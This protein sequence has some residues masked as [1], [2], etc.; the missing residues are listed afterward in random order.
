MSDEQ[1][2]QSGEEAGPLCG[3]RLA[4]A[5]EELQISLVEIAK[6]LHLDEQKVQALEA[7]DFAPLGAPVFA[8]GH[9][10]KYA[11]L[12][13]VD[14]D[15]ILMGYH[16][17]TRSEGLPPVVSDRKAPK[18]AASPTPWVASAVVILII[19]AVAA[20]FFLLRP[21]PGDEE[22]LPPAQAEPEIV[23]ESSAANDTA[24]TGLDDAADLIE[25][26]P[27]SAAEPIGESSEQIEQAVAPAAAAPIA[28]PAAVATGQLALNLNFIGDCWTEITDGNGRR[29]F[30]D[31]G[32]AGRTVS[33]AG[34]APLSVLLGNAD[35]V[36]LELNGSD[37]PI[38]DADRRGQTARFTLA[39]P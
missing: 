35:N 23:D 39:A 17:L 9:L 27:E 22:S 5:R 30:F 10:K 14:V 18:I 32:R 29:L 4:A 8:K 24:D 2:S 33:V 38:S 37:Y 31:L 16:Q 28:V 11:Q 12:V 21:A 6:E 15:D 36:R 19:V 25:P 7:D 20:W 34:A 3:E 13:K 1:E 26:R